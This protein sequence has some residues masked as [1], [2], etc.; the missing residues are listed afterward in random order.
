MAREYRII[1][2]MESVMH[3]VLLLLLVILVGVVASNAR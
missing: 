1:V 3:A 2:F